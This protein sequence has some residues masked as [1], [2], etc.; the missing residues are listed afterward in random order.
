MSQRD[1]YAARGATR[2][3]AGSFAALAIAA[4]LGHGAQAATEGWSSCDLGDLRI[5]NDFPAARADACFRQSA[6]AVAV[7]VMPEQANINPSPWYAFRVSAET[8][9][10]V[11]VTLVYGQGKHRYPPK[12]SRDGGTWVPLAGDAVRV[13][14]DGRT[15]T[16]VLDVGPQPLWVAAQELWPAE[17]YRA[18]LRR[19]RSR[20]GVEVSQLG[21]S[22]QGRP[23]ELLRTDPGQS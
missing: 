11:A 18:F 13:A 10:R 5:A 19:M 16:L 6:D 1:R 12:V 8:P 21:T 4:L 3:R 9:R 20:S 17:R 22:L 23:I 7:L 14:E 2:Q 15:A